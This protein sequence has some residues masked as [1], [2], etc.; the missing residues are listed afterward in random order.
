MDVYV[1]GDALAN[2]M[3]NVCLHGGQISLVAPLWFGGVFHV[4]LDRIYPDIQTVSICQS[5]N[6]SLCQTVP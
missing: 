4:M 5:F 1:Y 2:H 6:D 3:Y